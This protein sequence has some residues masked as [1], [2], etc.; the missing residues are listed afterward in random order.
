MDPLLNDSQHLPKGYM[1][2]GGDSGHWP[3]GNHYSSTAPPHLA[4][5]P[6][7]TLVT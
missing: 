7:L 3:W 4:L 6:A 1:A 5:L 2:M